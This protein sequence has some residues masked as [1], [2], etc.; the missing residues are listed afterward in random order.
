METFEG[1][2]KTMKVILRRFLHHEQKEKE[3]NINDNIVIICRHYHLFY[4]HFLFM[5]LWLKGFEP[6]LLGT[7]RTRL[8]SLIDSTTAIRLIK[9]H[10]I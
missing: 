5:S 8:E 3:K 4:I 6:P 7:P 9:T 2:L 1:I 10:G